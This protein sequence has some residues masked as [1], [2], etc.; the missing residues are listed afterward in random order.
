MPSL[1]A[2]RSLTGAQLRL[3]RTAARLSSGLRINSAQDDPAGLAISSRMQ[4]QSRALSV[5]VRNLN[6]M[7]SLVQVAEDALSTIAENLQR[8]RV[9]SI[10]AANATNGAPERLV[11]QLEVQQLIEASRRIQ[12]TTRFNGLLL[13]DG[14]F[15]VQAMGRDTN[16]HL[17]LCIEPLFLPKTTDT[18]FRY[19]QMSQASVTATPN[20]ALSAGDLIINQHNIGASF[21]GTK[22]GQTTDSAWAIA[23]AINQAMITDITAQA[24]TTTVTGSSTVLPNGGNVLAGQI[25]ING[26]PVQAGNVVNAINNISGQTG[27]TARAIAGQPLPG[28]PVQIPYT[29]VL[30]ASDGCNIDVSGA[31]AFG[32][33]DTHAVGSVTITGPLAERPLSNL[34]IAGTNP[35]S[36]GLSA[37]AIAAVDSGDPVLVPLD[38]AAGYDLNPNLL[39]ADSA[40]ATIATMDR[41]L[42]K[43]SSLRAMLGAAQNAMRFRSN[44]LMTTREATCAAISRIEDADYASE[45]SSLSREKILQQAGMAMCAQANIEGRLVL[46]LLLRKR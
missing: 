19:A 23:N 38:E 22:P 24:S 6:D 17:P 32:I 3:E 41:K 1:T 33:S 20:A 2:S 10:Q 13:L 14:S 28:P 29:L 34:F 11:L 46:A 8:I 21:A 40:Q 35:G 5:N 43:A 44:Y 26:V 45:L 12:A 18:L 31:A 16:G 15:Q 25:V 30:S 36:A 9:L 7:V 42:S 4:S 39:S 37:G 27:V